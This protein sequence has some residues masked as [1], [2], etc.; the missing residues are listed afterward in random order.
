MDIL[1][2]CEKLQM[3]LPKNKTGEAAAGLVAC[4]FDNCLEFLAA[5]FDEVLASQG[6]LCLGKV[7]KK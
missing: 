5:N 3:T 1:L 4:L 7:S 6:F 2:G